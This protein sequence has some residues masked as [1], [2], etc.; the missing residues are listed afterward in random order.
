MITLNPKHEQL[1]QSQLSTGRYA[2]AEEVL[3]LALNLLTHLDAESQ[4]WLEE[5]RAKLA[6]GIAELDRGEGVDGPT[7]MNQFLEKFQNAPRS[8]K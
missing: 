7:V 5:T 3:E 6:V 8:G 2:N 1:I 4:T